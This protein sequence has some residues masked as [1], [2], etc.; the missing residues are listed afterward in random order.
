MTRRPVLP[1]ASELFRMTDTSAAA[2]PAPVTELTT[3]AATQSSPALR[4]NGSR[5]D[6]GHPAEPAPLALV[7][8]VA[9]GAPRIVVDELAS[10]RATMPAAA[11]LRPQQTRARVEK[12]RT[13]HE[14]KIT[15]YCSADELLALETA[16]LTLR[17]QHGVATDRGRIV[18]EAIAVLLDDLEVHGENSVLVRRLRK[19]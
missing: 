15:V 16:R 12:G 5:G 14:E 13:R 19:H 8:D 3:L 18:R 1:G 7:P 6:D 2:Q 11:P 10:H 4:S 17:G 9:G